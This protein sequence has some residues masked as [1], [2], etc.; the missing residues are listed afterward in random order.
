MS[1]RQA[2][3]EQREHLLAAELSAREL[4]ETSQ[5]QLAEQ[6]A[7]LREFDEAKTQFLATASHELR[8]PLTSIVSFVELIKD[9]EDGLGPDTVS[10][11][12]VI[13]RNA[14]RLLRLV[15]DLLLLSRIEAG[16]MPLELAPVSIPEL[17]GQVG[18]SASPAAAKQGVRIEICAEDGPAV[19]A[20]ET[21]LQQVFDNLVS[22]AVKFTSAGGTVRIAASHDDSFWT[23]E[24]EDS[25]IGI[26]PAELDHIFDRFVRASNARSASLPGT[27]LGLSVV[28]ATTEQHGGRVEA[29]STVGSGARFRVFLPVSRS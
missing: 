22:N 24:V 11:L 15:G 6:N 21:R 1:E 19:Q 26:P 7:A 3:E 16:S 28:K 2:L 29:E 4:A 23:I 27:G 14:N 10:S 5:R 8:T 20:D 25:G 13:A 12:E 18:R 17:V 9:S